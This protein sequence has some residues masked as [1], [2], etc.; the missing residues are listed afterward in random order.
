MGNNNKNSN[1]NLQQLQQ[2]QRDINFE[3]EFVDTTIEKIDVAL[4]ELT[5]G[6]GTPDDTVLAVL[7]QYITEA[8]TSMTTNSDDGTTTTDEA[9]YIDNI[10]YQR[11]SM[12]V[13]G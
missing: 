2:E 9:S 5:G 1:N 7:D 10:A 11:L 3:V 8:V 12:Y 13:T 6:R 4:D